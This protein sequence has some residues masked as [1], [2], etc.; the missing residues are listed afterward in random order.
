M[1]YV[2]EAGW[3]RIARVAVGVALLALGFGVVGGTVGTVLGVV[4]LVPLLTGLVGYCPIY[5][6]LH[7]RTNHRDGTTTAA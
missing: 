3:D 4:G 7:V 1:T 6:L 2:N 5:S